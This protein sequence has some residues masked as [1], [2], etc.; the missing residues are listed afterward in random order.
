VIGT[1]FTGVSGWEHPQWDRYVYPRPKPRGFHGLEFLGARFGAVE[2]RSTF[3][4]FPR[5]EL[6]RLWMT[7]VS[8]SPNFRFTALLHHRFTLERSLDPAE[9]NAF[10]EGLRPILNRQLLGALVMKFPE[11]FAF[12]VENRQFLVALRRCFQGFPLVAELPHD[13]WLA[14]EALGTL[15]DYHIGFCNLDLPPADHAMP[16]SAYLTTGVGYFKLRAGN[17]HLY[18]YA[19]MEEWKRRIVRVQRFANAVYVVFD[20]PAGGRAVINALQMQGMLE[21]PAAPSGV[22]AG[23]F[24]GQSLAA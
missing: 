17:A 20:N 9:V 2:I 16:P 3:H 8:R 6:S 4:R 7:R 15:I 24:G 18:S 21:A 11:R 23:L 12:N 10:R 5:A 13:S 22:P 14:Q 1:T 19:E